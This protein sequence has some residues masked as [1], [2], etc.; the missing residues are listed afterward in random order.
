[1]NVRHTALICAGVITLASCSDSSAGPG[2]LPSCGAHGTPLA[3]AV[4]AYTSVDPASDSGCVTFAANT[5][6]DTAEYLVLPWS[7]GGPLGASAL[8]TLESAS[9]SAAAS[10]RFSASAYSPLPGGRPAT[11]RGPIAIAFDHYLRDLE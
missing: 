11:S 6:A 1:M 4:G 8:F 7:A 5:G 2:N 3:L 9:P 10:S